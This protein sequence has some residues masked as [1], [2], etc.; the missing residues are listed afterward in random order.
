MRGLTL[1]ALILVVFVNYGLI[2][3]AQSDKCPMFSKVR[4]CINLKN[5]LNVSTIQDI[6]CD[7][8]YPNLIVDTAAEEIGMN[9]ELDCQQYCKVLK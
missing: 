3:N 5:H 2:I 7:L 4:L 8:S 9:N 6:S 1:E